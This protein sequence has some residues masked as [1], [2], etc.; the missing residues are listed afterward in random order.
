MSS[1]EELFASPADNVDAADSA[2]AR[3]KEYSTLTDNADRQVNLDDEGT[4]YIGK[5]ML[6]IYQKYRNMIYDKIIRTSG[7]PTST[8]CPWYKRY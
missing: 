6:E 4:F 2:A 7:W 1:L 8:P 3:L 5:K